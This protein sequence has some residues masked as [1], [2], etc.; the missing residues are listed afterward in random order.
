VSND[1]VVA[2]QMEKE[3]FQG[4]L[5][6]IRPNPDILAV[7]QSVLLLLL[8]SCAYVFV[9]YDRF[10]EERR[11]VSRFRVTTSLSSMIDIN[12]FFSKAY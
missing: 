4:G 5:W 12:A 11:V 10:G 7:R 2:G 9:A 3:P 1:A 8:L 6:T